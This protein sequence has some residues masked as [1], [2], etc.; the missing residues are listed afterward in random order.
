M[1]SLSSVSPSIG[2]PATSDPFRLCSRWRLSVAPL[3]AFQSHGIRRL[4]SSSSS[5]S[6]YYFVGVSYSLERPRRRISQVSFSLRGG[7]VEEEEDAD[8]RE[9]VERALHLDGTIP[10]T[11]GEFVKRMSSR[12]YDMR[13]HLHQTFNSSNYDGI[14]SFFFVLIIVGSSTNLL[15]ILPCHTS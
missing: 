6:S 12:A 11:L 2:L 9:D 8:G 13:R 5:S 1:D 3:S 14:A 15:A 7:A 4:S 10:G